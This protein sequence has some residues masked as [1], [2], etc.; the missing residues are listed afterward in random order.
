MILFCG[1]PS[2][3]P[4][5]LAIE[6]A[7]ALGAEFI[8][9]NQR[10]APYSDAML[11][12]RGCHITGKLWM[13]EREF[14]FSLF[15][16]VYTRLMDNYD[17]PEVRSLEARGTGARTLEKCASLHYI[18]NE[19]FEMAECPVL[20]RTSAMGSNGSK[21][22]QTQLIAAAGFAV[23]ETLVTNDPHEVP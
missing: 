19:W 23:P 4:L 7:E 15:S 3:P 16:G 14:P 12:V 20:N 10:H 9:F 21:P 1:I 22:H 8:V 5:A 17:L 13:W 6:A 18:L 11:D 2:E